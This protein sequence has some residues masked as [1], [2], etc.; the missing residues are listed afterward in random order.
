MVV[1]MEKSENRFHAG[2]KEPARDLREWNFSNL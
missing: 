2:K 1:S